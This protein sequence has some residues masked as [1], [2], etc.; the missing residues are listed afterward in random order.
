[1]KEVIETYELGKKYGKTWGLRRAS[2]KVKRGELVVLAGP[3]GAGKTTT[4]RILTTFLKP[5]KGEAY[6]LGYNTLKEYKEIRKR[7]AYLPQD[8]SIPRDLTPT[9]ILKWNLVMRGLSLKEAEKRT[10][11]WLKIMGLWNLRNKTC[12]NLSGGERRRV[13][14]AM[15]LATEAEVIFLDEPTAGLDVEI[16]HT[17]WRT[18]R[19][20]VS[21]GITILMTTHDM[22]EAQT[23]ADRVIM[24]NNG[25]TIL[26][27]SPKELIDKVPFEFKIV[28]ERNE[29]VHKLDNFSDFIDLGDRIIV[30]CRKY[31]DVLEILNELGGKIKV[32]SISKVGLDDAYLYIIK[33]RCN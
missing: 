29:L 13:A 23:I 14:V 10:E 33:R 27:G 21:N 31:D 24:I 15:T 7:I 12:W 20:V 30:Y 22:L 1:M 5:T 2:F 6:V 28:V 17:V 18:L 25:E 3:N 9:S 4:V 32:Y 11:K 16:K 26:E 19:E 8:Y